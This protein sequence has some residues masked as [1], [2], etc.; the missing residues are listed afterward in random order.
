MLGDGIPK[1]TIRIA[2][3]I[4]VESYNKLLFLGGYLELDASRLQSYNALLREQLSLL[5]GIKSAIEAKWYCQA[6]LLHQKN[7]CIETLKE[8]VSE[9]N[10]WQERLVAIHKELASARSSQK[11]DRFIALSSEKHELRGKL[12]ASSKAQAS[13]E[14]AL[15]R[16]QDE[17]FELESSE[18]DAS[19]EEGGEEGIEASNT[20]DD[21]ANPYPH[22]DKSNC[23]NDDS[24]AEELAQCGD[25]E[26]RGLG[27][28][29]VPAGLLEQVEEETKA[30]AKA[31]ANG[32]SEIGDSEENRSMI[33]KIFRLI[34]DHHPQEQRSMSTPQSNSKTKFRMSR[35]DHHKRGSF[36][37][38][39]T[40]SCTIASDDHESVV[41]AGTTASTATA[42]RGG[43]FLS[44]FDSGNSSSS[45]FR[46]MVSALSNAGRRWST[47]KASQEQSLSEL[48][49]QVCCPQR[50]GPF[51]RWDASSASAEHPSVSRSPP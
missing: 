3:E 32:S 1:E 39:T 7:D 33:S 4:S 46:G 20:T 5:E 15:K 6:S 42:R 21:V 49:Q 12:D 28:E 45:S 30:H 16:A 37:T 51:D 47:G 24:R 35:Q 36:S 26:A 11:M 48:Y 31:S 25:D 29:G 40:A 8:M 43:R 9:R 41:S 38:V 27:T 18:H 50:R 22:S 17:I 34:G 14:A 44:R 19:G 13:L 2:K 23:V 10:T